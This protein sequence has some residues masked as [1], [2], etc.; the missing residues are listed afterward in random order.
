MWD[1]KLAT[2]G[3]EMYRGVAGGPTSMEKDVMH[4]KQRGREGTAHI[5]R[6]ERGHTGI[7]GIK[8]K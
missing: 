3:A 1:K 4:A 6:K 2:V 5:K 8:D 7:P